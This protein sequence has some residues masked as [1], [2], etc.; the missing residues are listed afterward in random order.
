MEIGCSA[1]LIRGQSAEKHITADEAA[2]IWSQLLEREDGGRKEGRMEQ[3][4]KKTP[5]L[6]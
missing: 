2:I 6:Y 5:T 1:E 3:K 4:K